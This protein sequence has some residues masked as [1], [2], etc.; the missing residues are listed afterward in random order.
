MFDPS[1]FPVP[2]AGGSNPPERTSRETPIPAVGTV[3]AGSRLG[4][5]WTGLFRLVRT[6]V[7]I[8]WES[9]ALAVKWWI[10]FAAVLLLVLAPALAS[11]QPARTFEVLTGSTN[12]D[13]LRAGTMLTVTEWRITD[14]DTL[15]LWVERTTTS[16]GPS[17]SRAQSAD[18]VIWCYPEHYPDERHLFPGARVVLSLSRARAGRRLITFTS[19]A[20]YE[21]YYAN[22]LG[23]NAIALH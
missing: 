15:R 23:W 11:A 18:R 12:P 2:K 7:A 16:G 8:G 9:G 5:G 4:Q 10:R 14:A 19:E 20:T 13:S 6:L 22:E 1:R 3:E 17:H 21:K